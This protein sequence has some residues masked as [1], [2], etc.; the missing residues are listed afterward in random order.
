MSGRFIKAVQKSSASEGWDFSQK[1]SVQQ[2]GSEF[3][4][5]DEQTPLPGKVVIVTSYNNG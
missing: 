3:I 5:T 1:Y 2:N 4:I